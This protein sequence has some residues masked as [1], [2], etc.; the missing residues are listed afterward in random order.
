MAPQLWSTVAG[1]RAGAHLAVEKRLVAK[2]DLVRVVL[3]VH[4]G[5]L[6]EPPRERVYLELLRQLTDPISV[7]AVRA[8]H[9]ALEVVLNLL[10]LLL[11]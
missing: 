8:A 7:V 11:D 1:E 6:A 3:G 10:Q 2:P 5:T 9:V 4:H